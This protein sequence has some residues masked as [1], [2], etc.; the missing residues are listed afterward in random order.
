[1]VKKYYFACHFYLLG[2]TRGENMETSRIFSTKSSAFFPPFNLPIIIATQ[3]CKIMK[4]SMVGKKPVVM[5][6]GDTW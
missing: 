1:M 2:A 6:K 5:E 3:I 4:D